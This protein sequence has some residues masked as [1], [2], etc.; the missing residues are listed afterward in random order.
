MRCV[1][2]VFGRLLIQYRIFDA[3]NHNLLFTTPSIW[4]FAH[5]VCMWSSKFVCKNVQLCSSS[6][7]GTSVIDRI[8]VENWHWKGLFEPKDAPRILE[9]LRPY[10]FLTWDFTLRQYLRI[11]SKGLFSTKFQ[12]VSHIDSNNLDIFPLL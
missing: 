1:C 12:K 3:W 8:T 6:S 5:E 2:D 9:N 7:Y 10:Y 11:F 4:A